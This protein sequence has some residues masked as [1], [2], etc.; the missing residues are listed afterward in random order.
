MSEGIRRIVTGR[1]ADGKAVV[2]ADT[3]APNVKQ[4]PNRPGVVINNLWLTD[5][6][7]AKIN[8]P[9]DA[10]EAPMGLEP[11][12]NGTVFRIVEFPPE[13]AYIDTIDSDTAHAAF[14]DMGAG[15]AKDASSTT[16]HPF[17][18]A[19]ETVD[20][21]IVLEGETYLGLDDSEVLMKAGEVCIQ[22]GTNHAWSNRSDAPCKIVF[23]LIN[24]A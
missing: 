16:P 14:A 20:Y 5:G 13:A 9:E 3:K 24:G 1:D 6:A 15:H 21:A 10:T 2:I 22:R 18:H 23:V 11:P 12:A 7:P 8:G 4:S 19:T 17:M